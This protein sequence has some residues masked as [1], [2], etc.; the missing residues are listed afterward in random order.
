M[1]AN[2][3]R[4]LAM[5]VTAAVIGAVVMAC[6]SGQGADGE[7]RAVFPTGPPGLTAQITSPTDEILNFGIA[8]LY[9]ASN[10]RVTIRAV[11]LISPSGAAIR[12]ITYRAYPGRGF[13]TPGGLQGD[14]TKTCPQHF[15]PQPMT[16][17][18]I[19]AHSYVTGEI[20]VSFK[21]VKPGH[22]RLGKVRIDYIS[23]GHRG[24]QLLYL[25]VR[26]T[27]VPAASIPGLVQPFRCGR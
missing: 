1:I 15:R 23:G 25:S 19:A 17:I 7:Y 5:A 2:R 14:L 9:N 26:I 8:G 20:I 10:A 18:S 4:V 21:I 22:Y 12:D 24:W 13:V 3:A 16:S 6:S 11:R 27:A